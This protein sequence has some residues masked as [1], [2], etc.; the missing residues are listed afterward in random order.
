MGQ[1]GRR[2]VWKDEFSVLADNMHFNGTGIGSS[3]LTNLVEIDMT[4]MD[5]YNGRE[6][7]RPTNV[8]NET[9]PLLTA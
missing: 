7:R 4:R 9:I 1:Q 6:Q 5:L 2:E 8:G 3:P